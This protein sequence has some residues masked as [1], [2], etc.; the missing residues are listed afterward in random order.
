[1]KFQGG[2]LAGLVVAVSFAA[3]LNV[4][5]T[6][7]TLGLLA[8]G[9]VLLTVSMQEKAG[10]SP[11]FRFNWVTVDRPAPVPVLALR[12]QRLSRPRRGQASKGFVHRRIYLWATR[13]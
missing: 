13:D 9:G 6:V 4:Y 11:E 10:D 2:E 12:T 1:M 7:A 8:H 3:G 5:A